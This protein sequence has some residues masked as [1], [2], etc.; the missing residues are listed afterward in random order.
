MLRRAK[1][2]PG[3]TGPTAILA[4]LI[5]LL[6]PRL[7]AQ[8]LVTTGTILRWHRRLIT[9]KWT[10]PHR[11]GRPPVSAEVAALVERFA[12]ENTGWGYKRIQSE[13]LKV[14]HRVSASTIRRILKAPRIPAS[15]AA[16]TSARPGP[17]TRPPTPPDNGASAGPCSA[18]SSANANEPHKDPVRP[19]AEFWNRMAGEPF[20]L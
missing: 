12:K 5:R 2:R 4:A 14:G 17:T 15:A 3:W 8:R 6:P 16:A 1:P 7:R 13:L 11:T 20:D 9:R 18:A 19:V 10:Y